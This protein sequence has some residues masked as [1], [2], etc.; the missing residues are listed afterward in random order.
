M[1][2]QTLGFPCPRS[3]LMRAVVPHTLISGF[4]R[5]HFTSGVGE[6][7]GEL[8]VAGLGWSRYA[9]GGDRVGSIRRSVARDVWSLV[10]GRRLWVL[11][12]KAATLGSSATDS[13]LW[14]GRGCCWWRRGRWRSVSP[15][16]KMISVAPLSHSGGLDF[17]HGS[18]QNPRSASR[19]WQRRRLRVPCPLGDTAMALVVP[20]LER[21][22]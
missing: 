20:L 15:S 18:A 9:A 21:G 11:V 19:C 7:D 17:G 1:A 10:E 4:G 3:I 8:G 12:S 16:S 14:P 6:A 5:R 2:P 22:G 13:S